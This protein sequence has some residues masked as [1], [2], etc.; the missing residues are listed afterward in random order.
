MDR[1]L[2]ATIGIP[3]CDDDPHVLSLAL[4]AI[5]AEPV[6]HPPLIVD[7]SSTDRI[8]RVIDA[9]PEKLRYVRFKESSGV[10]ESRNRIVALAE[11]RYLLFLDADAVP[12]H[13]WANALLAAFGAAEGVALVGA[14]IIPGWPQHAPR[15][16]DTTIALELLG[17]L[18]LGFEPCELPR[19]MGT[20]F[21]ADRE[22]LPRAE[23]FSPD[24][25]RRRAGL[26]AWEEVQ[27]SLDV[28]AAGGRIRYEPGATVRHHV[29]PD[30]LSWRWMLRRAYAAG[31]ETR[32]SP[33]RLASF[34]RPLTRRDRA[35]QLF[36]APLF[37]AGRFRGA[38]P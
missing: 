14:R 21:A 31:R 16:F 37:L 34:P 3:T 19:V 9:R 35:F 13:G 7:M 17:M 36:T 33:E 18:D 30:R 28:R 26:L 24:L 12:L 38:D 4:D 2:D 15:L 27:L 20:S 23:P 22:R 6:A 25:G 10:A 8:G 5:A 29:R 1:R 11:T 32:R